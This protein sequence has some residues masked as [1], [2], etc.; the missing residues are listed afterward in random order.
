MDKNNSSSTYDFDKTSTQHIL[1]NTPVKIEPVIANDSAYSNL[2]DTDLYTAQKLHSNINPLENE[3][4][5]DY[6][7]NDI[8]SAEFFTQDN[9]NSLLSSR[10]S[11]GNSSAT[12]DSLYRQQIP[13]ANFQEHQF[14]YAQHRASLPIMQ[15]S[16]DL[17]NPSGA[18]NMSSTG[19]MDMNL[20]PVS[21]RRY[22]EGSIPK[23]ANRKQRTNSNNSATSKNEKAG[24]EE[25]L[26]SE[27]LKRKHFLERNRQAALKCRQ[28]KKQWLANLQNRVEFLTTDNEQLQSQATILRE[29]VINLKTLLLTHRDCKVAQANGTTL[30]MIQNIPSLNAQQ[31]QQYATVTNNT[32]GQTQQHFQ[33]PSTDHHQI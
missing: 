22:T 15:H 17:S 27:E 19:I 20:N 11:S 31:Q 28:R 23:Y 12:F 33:Q 18:Q 29:E 5:I 21:Q 4:W 13:S 7:N 25:F 1:D 26:N 3:P 16:T 32:K 2:N 14:N 10:D 30:S 8:V 6:R 9:M 24:D